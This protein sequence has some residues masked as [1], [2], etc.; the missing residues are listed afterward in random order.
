MNRSWVTFA[1]LAAI[2]VAAGCAGQQRAAEVPASE[3]TSAG[4]IAA[5]RASGID[6]GVEVLLRDSLHVLRGKRVGLITNHT[7][8]DREGTSTADLLYRAPGVRLTALYGPEHGIR[9]V[10]ADGEKIASSVDRKSVV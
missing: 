4:V 10:A 7:G 9:G 6:L 3:Q 1:A 8:R 5:A 2:A